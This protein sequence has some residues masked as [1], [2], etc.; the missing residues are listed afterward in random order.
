MVCDLLKSISKANETYKNYY[1]FSFY[2]K[3]TFFLLPGCF[4]IF[5]Q[6]QPLVFL[7]ILETSYGNKATMRWEIEVLVK[8]IERQTLFAF[9]FQFN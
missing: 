8:N 1:T 3:Q 7:R 4:L 9:C 6:I 5:C 2:K